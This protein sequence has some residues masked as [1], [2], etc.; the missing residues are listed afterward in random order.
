LP[1]PGAIVPNEPGEPIVS[2][3]VDGTLP[4]IS[5]AA[6]VTTTPHARSGTKPDATSRPPRRWPRNSGSL[7]DASVCRVL[8]DDGRGR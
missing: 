1:T 8:V 3:S 2:A 4:T 5:P 6:S 7:E